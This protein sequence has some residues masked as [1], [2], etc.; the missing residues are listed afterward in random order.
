[1]NQGAKKHNFA[2]SYRLSTLWEIVDYKVKVE[3]SELA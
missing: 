1:M 2:K 3:A